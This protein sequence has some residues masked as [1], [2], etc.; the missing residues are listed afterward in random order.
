MRGSALPLAAAACRNAWRDGVAGDLVTWVP[1]SRADRRVRGYDHAEV[2][3]RRIAGRLGL[4]AVPLLRLNRPKSD[5]TALSAAQ[6]RE[7]LKDAFVAQAVHARVVIVDDV[8]TTGAT[9]CTCAGALLRAGATSVD[10]LVGCR[11]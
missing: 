8:M 2:L 10:G 1:C 9:I 3:G 11:A 6:R 4:P 5:Q 7:N